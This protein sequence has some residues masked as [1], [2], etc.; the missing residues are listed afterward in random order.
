MVCM[1]SLGYKNSN[2]A[3]DIHL[4]KNSVNIDVII[5]GN[6]S[7]NIP[8]GVM[9]NNSGKEVLIDNAGNR[10]SAIGKI[11]I[12]FNSAGKKNRIS[13]GAQAITDVPRNISLS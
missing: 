2:N 3:D 11:E 12:C 5:S 1:S 7:E 6:N 10:H 9:L 4:A 13:F 8:A